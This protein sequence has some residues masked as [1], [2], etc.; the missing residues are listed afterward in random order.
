[1]KEII[2]T[3]GLAM[4]YVVLGLGFCALFWNLIMLMST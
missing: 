1:M 4:F 2:D 3:Y